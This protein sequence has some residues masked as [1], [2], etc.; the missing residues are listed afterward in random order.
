MARMPRIIASASRIGSEPRYSSFGIEP[1]GA[2]SSTVPRITRSADQS[3]RMPG[4]SF[5]MRVGGGFFHACGE[6]AA[7][8]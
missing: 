4:S 2:N 7:P 3:S 1:G 8:L 5:R 6:C